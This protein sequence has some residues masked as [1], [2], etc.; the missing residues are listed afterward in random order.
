MFRFRTIR[1]A[2]LI[3]IPFVALAAPARAD[4]AQSAKWAAE[5]TITR[6]TYGIPHIDGPTDLSVVFGFGYAQAEDYFWQLEDSYLQSIGRYAEAVGKRGLQADILNH[7]FEIAE[8]SEADYGKEPRLARAVCDAFADGINFYLKTHPETKP[9]LITHFEGW[10]VMAFG[11]FTML[12]WCYER[13]GVVRAEHDKYM[14]LLKEGKGSNLWAVG[15]S[16]TKDK[17]AMLFV[18]PHQPWFGPGQWWEGHVKSGEG[19]NFSGACFFGTP[20]PTI[21]HNEFL[22]WTHTANKPDIGDVYRETFDDPANPLSYKYDQGHRKATE[23]K[24][25]IK[26]RQRD[27]SMTEEEYTF[28]KT[29]HGPIVQREDATHCL[30][31]RIAKLFEDNRIEQGVQMNKAKNLKEFY[32]AVSGMNLL[33]FNIGYADKD[34]NFGYI[35]HGV[36]PK[37]DPAFDWSGIVDGSTSATE[38]KGF[39][40]L[41]DFPQIINPIDGYVQNCNQSPF[42]TNDDDTP[43]PGDYPAYMTQ[44]KAY[45]NRR[46]QVSRR[47]LRA[48]HDLTFEDWSKA[49][50]DSEMLWPKTEL[51][52]YAL[53]LEGVRAKDAAFAAKVDPYLKHMLDWDFVNRADCTQSTLAAAWYE[54]MYGG[55]APSEKMK[56]EFIGDTRKQF[57]ALVSVA[58]EMEKIYGTW[59]VPYGEVYRI[60]RHAEVADF[61]QTL[62]IFKDD[63]PSVPCVAGSGALGMSYN[64]YFTPSS[65]QRKR[66]YGVV[67][68]SFMAVYEFGERVKAKTLL[69]FGESADPKSP[70]YFDQ[71]QLYSKKEFKP[72]WFY[73]DEIQAHVE[74]VYHPG[75]KPK[76]KGEV[77]S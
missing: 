22:G 25:K 33:M 56:P 47:H 37:R 30:S 42:T 44:E 12:D 76:L 11:R 77:G 4:E 50:V 5:V 49:V 19:W 20:Y 53:K 65:T 68:G 17:T 7:N 71:A 41:E 35:Y 9:R 64:A 40:A 73:Q 58:E 60:Q 16:R 1:A 69:Q 67:G 26:V 74:S 54:E 75:E 32:A 24:V 2:A 10:M 45:D 27:G 18:N 23:R 38:W 39:H 70:H 21:G 52:E 46:A 72:G 13:T 57:E 15:P 8:R 14:E 63:E 55:L 48:L 29:H 31:V 59:K 3:M 36:V 51:P 28:R 66:R 43:T 62:L 34:G 61:R 6:D